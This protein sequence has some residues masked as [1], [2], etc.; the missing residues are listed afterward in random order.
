MKKT[1]LIL[2]LAIFATGFIKAIGDISLGDFEDGV[3]NIWMLYGESYEIVDN[4]LIAEPNTSDKVL[5]NVTINQYQGISL[6]D[7]TYMADSFSMFSF[8]VYNATGAV[9]FIVNVHGKTSDGSD[10]TSSYYPTTTE[11]EWLHFEVDLTTAEFETF[12]T[13]TQ[14]DLQNNTAATELY[15]DNMLLTSK[16]KEPDV[17]AISVPT[18]KTNELL[19]FPN[20]ASSSELIRFTGDIEDN[21]VVELYNVV[22]QLKLTTSLNN[23]MLNIS[24]LNSGLYFV[25]VGNKVAKLVIR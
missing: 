4:P 13:I 12:D 2:T 18:V 21:C 20:P 1:L 7:L 23:G 24:S 8:D 19:F 22:G 11:G 15:W 6:H 16:Y 10:V 9:D 14:L 25:K 17:S 3:T 5:Q